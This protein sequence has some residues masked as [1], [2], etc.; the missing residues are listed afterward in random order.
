M[1]EQFEIIKNLTPAQKKELD[2][3]IQE[4][5]LQLYQDPDFKHGRI[6]DLNININLLDEV[7]LNLTL[8]FGKPQGDK[9]NGR[10]TEIYK[11]PSEDEYLKELVDHGE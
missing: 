5:Y 9:G 8:E 4:L 10:V 1:K 7:Y 2:K 3:D 11:Y 6:K